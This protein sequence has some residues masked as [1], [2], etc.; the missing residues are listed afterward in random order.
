MNCWP[1]QTRRQFRRLITDDKGGKQKIPFSPS[2]FPTKMQPKET[3]KSLST[4]DS[5]YP[6]HW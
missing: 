1:K 3:V 5:N 6:M 4:S 2:F